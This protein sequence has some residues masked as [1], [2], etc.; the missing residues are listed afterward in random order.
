LG[1]TGRQPQSG[2]RDAARQQRSG[3]DP[4][5]S[6][7]HVHDVMPLV[8]R[9]LAASQPLQRIF[10]LA[11]GQHMGHL[12]HLFASSRQLLVSVTVVM[13]GVVVLVVA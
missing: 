6:E 4:V 7:V 5:Q 12:P 3:N 2:H 8:R 13:T 1:G 9:S 10:R 11:R